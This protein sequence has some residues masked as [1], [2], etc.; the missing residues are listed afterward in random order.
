MQEKYR[1][2]QISTVGIVARYKLWAGLTSPGVVFD[3]SSGGFAG[4]PT[5]T[6]IAPAYPGF[7]FNGTDDSIGVTSG[8]PSAVNTVLM[9]VN[10][11]DVAGVDFPIALAVSNQLIITTG[12]LSVAGFGGGTTVLYVDGVAG[13]T[14][15][16]NWHLI[17]ITDTV[18][19]G[20]D[21]IFIGKRP[22][23]PAFFKGLIGETLLYDRVLSPAEV[24]SVYELTKW[25]YPNN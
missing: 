2:P 17:G 18:A 15:T 8:G 5:G 24:K 4:T 11:T 13:T 21:S 23:P 6:D 14:V 20:G 19:S 9:W 7:L 25:R 16:A 22:L 1:K 10:P 3:Y 12:T